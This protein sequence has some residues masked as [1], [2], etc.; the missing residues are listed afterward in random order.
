MKISMLF[1]NILLAVVMLSPA[2]VFAQGDWNFKLSPYIWFA[3]VKGTVSTIP[4]A[5]SVPIEVSPSDALSD[6]EASLMLLF[7]AKKNRHG[8]L[9]DLLYTDTQSTEDLIP[10]IN[11]TMKSISKNKIF[12]TAYL[13][14]LYKKQNTVVDFFAGARYWKVDTELQ[15]GG[16]L[17]ILDGKSIRN[18]ESW[19][20]PLIGIKANTPLGD[21]RFYIAGGVTYGGFDVGSESFYDISANIGYQWNK[22]IGTTLGYRLFDVDYEEASFLY[23]VKQE[24]WLAGLTWTF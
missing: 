20:D 7:D 2:L 4:G 17:G 21:S 23:D 8:V 9:V 3:G 12:S 22:A 19:V 6:T 18:A 14:E 10:E 16:G 13:Y 24:G 5:P 1:R 11:L 15:F